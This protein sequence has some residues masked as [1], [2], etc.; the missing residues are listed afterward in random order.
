AGPEA[1][2][3]P[4][5]AP[6]RYAA[7]RF[8]WRVQ[9]AGCVPAGI[10]LILSTGGVVWPV[11]AV[12]GTAVIIGYAAA[13]VRIRRAALRDPGDPSE[14]LVRLSGLLAF[15]A[16]V[17]L[18]FLPIGAY[19]PGEVPDLAEGAVFAILALVLLGYL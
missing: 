1:A 8:T 2:P 15:G 16:G 12:V 13:L 11:R 6:L 7:A 17:L 14:V 5:D 3:E 18:V 10:L 19:W 9:R 4:P